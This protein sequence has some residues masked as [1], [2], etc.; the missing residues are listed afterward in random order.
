MLRNCWVS[1]PFRTVPV[2]LLSEVSWIQK[3]PS[4]FPKKSPKGIP[5]EGHAPDHLYRLLAQ[6]RK[7]LVMFRPLPPPWCAC[8]NPREKRLPASAPAP[9]HFSLSGVVGG[10]VEVTNL[11]LE[12]QWRGRDSCCP[13]DSLNIPNCS[14]LSSPSQD[15][16]QM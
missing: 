8:P 12:V 14:P 16:V 11:F 13:R 3:V 6:K 15:D 5:W 7:E 10:Q 1:L 2:S 4:G 9:S